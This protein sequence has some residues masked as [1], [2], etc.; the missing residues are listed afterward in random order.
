MAKETQIQNP[1]TTGSLRYNTYLSKYFTVDNFNDRRALVGSIPPYDNQDYCIT[2]IV[3]QG[4]L[5]LKIN[6]IRLDLQKQVNLFLDSRCIYYSATI[7]AHTVF[8]QFEEMLNYVVPIRKRVFCFQYYHLSNLFAERFR[9]NYMMLKREMLRPDFTMKELVIRSFIKLS[10]VSLLEAI[11]N[12]GV[13]EMTYEKSRQQKLFEEFIEL[14]DTHY[15]HERSV[16]FYAHK[17]GLTPK[18]LSMLS[19][20]AVQTSASSVISHY[21]AYRIKQLLYNGQYSIKQISEM[22]NFSTQSFFGRYFKRI[23]G[24]SPRQYMVQNSRNTNLWNNH[25]A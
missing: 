4:T 22:L 25:D 9:E 3:V 11:D 15:T 10:L 23:V 1:P 24:C 5:Q 8:D 20:A 18:Y 19:R 21:V 14:L 6:G 12:E 17:M 2:F 7:L 13:D 16:Q